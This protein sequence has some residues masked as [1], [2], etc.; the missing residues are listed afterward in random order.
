MSST[1][2]FFD[3]GAQAY[4]THIETALTITLEV[5]QQAGVLTS[6]PLLSCFYEGT[7]GLFFFYENKVNLAENKLN[8]RKNTI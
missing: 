3:F 7:L 4:F 2:I 1:S 6:F 5:L 8:R